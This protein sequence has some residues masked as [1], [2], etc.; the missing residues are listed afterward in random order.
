MKFQENGFEKWKES[1]LNREIFGRQIKDTLDAQTLC[2][3]I[4]WSRDSWS[5]AEKAMQ[6]RLQKAEEALKFY[7]Y[8]A[9]ETITIEVDGQRLTG[10][11]FADDK[12]GQRARDYF[13]EL[14]SHKGKLGSHNVR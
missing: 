3:V 7:A 8:E 4:A 11:K 2:T 12:W 13:K 5:A 9:R 14:G 1:F 10:I 6:E